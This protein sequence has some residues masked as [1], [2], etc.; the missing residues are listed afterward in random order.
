MD[1]FRAVATGRTLL[2]FELLLGSGQRIGDVLK[3]KWSDL[4][5]GGLNVKQGKT[6]KPLWVPL[7]AQLHAALDATPKRSVFILTNEAATGPW[8]YRGAAQ[9]IRKI[10]AQIGALDYDNHALRYT[11][12]VELL[13]AG[14]DD[15]VIA[16]V[17]G[18]STAMVRHYTRSARQKVRALKAREIRT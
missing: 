18:Q 3:M 2:A 1:A 8:S 12:A 17:P 9:A 6:G 7:T 15:D 5:D 14:A 11:A 4:E 10:R 13:N 16:A